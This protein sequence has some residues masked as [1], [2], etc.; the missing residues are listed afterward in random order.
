[1][2]SI[3]GSTVIPALPRESS[4]VA[5]GG[6]VADGNLQRGCF[7]GLLVPSWGGMWEPTRQGFEARHEDRHVV[8]RD[9]S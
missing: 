6:S 9:R 2:S 1:M 4:E 8:A 3:E 7:R 5:D